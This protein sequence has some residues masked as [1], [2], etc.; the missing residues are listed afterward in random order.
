MH[1]GK[2]EGSVDE[3]NF[4]K[5]LPA[6]IPANMWRVI[7]WR[8]VFGAACGEAEGITPLGSSLCETF[9]ALLLPLP[10]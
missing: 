5:Y 9:R 7:D 1:F 4:V 3:D 6:R 10:P 8:A 2:A